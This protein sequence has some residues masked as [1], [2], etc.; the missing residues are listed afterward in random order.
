M[1]WR[2]PVIPSSR[3][4]RMAFGAAR[5]RHAAYTRMALGST[6]SRSNHFIRRL[7][8]LK[9]AFLVHV[10]GQPA[11]NAAMRQSSGVE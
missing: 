7:A 9:R 11:V 8:D 1:R 6:P 4:P 2:P 5:L 10:I 3:W